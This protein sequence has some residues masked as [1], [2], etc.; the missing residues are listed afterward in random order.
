MP[1]KGPS[2]EEWERKL[3]RLK[4]GHMLGKGEAPSSKSKFCKRY[5]KISSCPMTHN[6]KGQSTLFSKSMPCRCGEHKSAVSD[7]TSCGFFSIHFIFVMV[8]SDI[9]VTLL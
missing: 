3:T 4:Y 7:F 2:D 8:V 5:K 1:N 6:Q 9:F